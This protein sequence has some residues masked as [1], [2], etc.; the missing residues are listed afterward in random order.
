MSE[1]RRILPIPEI[2][3]EDGYLV[4]RVPADPE[5]IEFVKE[6]LL[7]RIFYYIKY[8]L[9]RVKAGDCP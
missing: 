8:C 2:V 1:A 5:T 4:I 6:E 9:D 3:V 7:P